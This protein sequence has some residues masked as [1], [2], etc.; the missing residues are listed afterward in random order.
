MFWRQFRELLGGLYHPVGDYFVSLISLVLS[1]P[2]RNIYFLSFSSFPGVISSLREKKKIFFYRG[3]RQL[4]IKCRRRKKKY[5]RHV[6]TGKAPICMSEKWLNFKREK[7]CISRYHYVGK[8][9]ASWNKWTLLSSGERER[10]RIN[11]TRTKTK[12]I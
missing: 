5:S 3:R 12:E 1:C 11:L 6:T 10:A 2:P 4:S 9:R 7:I 8:S